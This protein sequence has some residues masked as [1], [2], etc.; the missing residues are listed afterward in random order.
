MKRKDSRMSTQRTQHSPP[1]VLDEAATWLVGGG[2]LTMA[3]FP[4]SLPLL[5]LTAASLVP[6]LVVPLAGAL[7]AAVAAVPI[8]LARRLA[9]WVIGARRGRSGQRPGPRVQPCGAGLTPPR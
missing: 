3:L 9:R 4:L 5:L 7:I 1:E 6:F 2:I 8:L